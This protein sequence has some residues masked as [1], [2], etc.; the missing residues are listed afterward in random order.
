MRTVFD[1]GAHKGEDSDYYL[2]KGFR[3]VAIEA[4]PVLADELREK[5]ATELS[6]GALILIEAAVADHDGEVDFFVNEKSVWGTTQKDWADRNQEM[7]MQSTLIRVPAVKFNWIIE[8]FGVPHYLKI[9]IEG[10]DM[11]C[12]HAL[13]QT[14]A[15]PSFIS[16]ESSK[17]SWAALILEFD[18]LEKLGYRRF[19]IIN[20]RWV[21]DQ[22]EPN[23]SR[24]GSYSNHIFPKD[25]SGLFGDDLPGPWLT[26]RQALTK[27]A[28][29]FV[30]YRLFGDNTI[31]RKL[32]S[33]MPLF[34]RRR[35]IPGWFDTHAAL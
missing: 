7:G 9:D 20:Q 26:K 18:L 31:G 25:S 6:S 28:L 8:K 27:Y 32:L 22:V 29:I 2:K 16:I 3:V 11:L 12:L 33:R 17:T 14:P 1:V 34:F 35:L 21:P 13:A 15:R 19:K 24:E 10:S 4:N 5:F 23:P 30:Q